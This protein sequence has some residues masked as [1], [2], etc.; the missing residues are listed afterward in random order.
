MFE[1][2][3]MCFRKEKK[4]GDGLGGIVL[5]ISSLSNKKFWVGEKLVWPKIN[6][7]KLWKNQNNG[8]EISGYNQ[9]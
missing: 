3:F 5:Y 4:K 6:L 1:D 7:N 9:I 8:W 2:V